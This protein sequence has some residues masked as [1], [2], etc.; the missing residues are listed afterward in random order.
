MN[1]AQHL[2]QYKD[3]TRERK[4]SSERLS[5]LHGGHEHSH[6]DRKGGW[7]DSPQQEDE[8][9]RRSEAGCRLREDA[10][11]LPFFTLSQMLEHGQSFPLNQFRKSSSSV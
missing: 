3:H 11:E 1:G 9:P 10:E 5:T 8:P 4:R 6:R 2:K 7:Q